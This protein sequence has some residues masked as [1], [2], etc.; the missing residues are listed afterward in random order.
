MVG[1]SG[2]YGRRQ[3]K[4]LG[5]V[6]SDSAIS[7]DTTTTIAETG[8]IVVDTTSGQINYVDANT[9]TQTLS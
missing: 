8:D 9:K 7:D 5:I 6:Y 2:L 4:R 3:G 1:N